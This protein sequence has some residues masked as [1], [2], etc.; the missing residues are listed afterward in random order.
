MPTCLPQQKDGARQMGMK[1]SG[2]ASRLFSLMM[3]HR[4]VYL[5]DLALPRSSVVLGY[6]Y[7][8][9]LRTKDE[10]PRGRRGEGAIRGALPLSRGLSIQRQNEMSL[11]LFPASIE[12]FVSGLV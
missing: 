8:E 4:R 9:Q 3:V 10:Y 6:N 11:L 7:A 5:L 2:L 1:F 12:R